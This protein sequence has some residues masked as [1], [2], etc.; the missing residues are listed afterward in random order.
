MNIKTK[1]MLAVFI[2]RDLVDSIDGF[3]ILKRGEAL[4][5][6]ERTELE[7]ASEEE[8]IVTFET[9]QKPNVVGIIV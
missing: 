9:L 6:E 2:I 1:D 7:Q 5:K 4:T 3:L 8:L